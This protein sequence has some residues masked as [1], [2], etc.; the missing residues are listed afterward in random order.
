MST[1]V[2]KKLLKIQEMINAA[3]TEAK[4]SASNVVKASG[5]PA[6]KSSSGNRLTDKKREA[7]NQAI[8]KGWKVG[9]VVEKYGISSATYYTLKSR[10]NQNEQSE[11]TGV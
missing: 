2:I 4:K 5:K 11:Q 1:K 7:I 8:R 9:K 3:L 6:A 10:M